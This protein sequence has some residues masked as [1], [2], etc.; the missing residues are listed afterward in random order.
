[1]L[2]VLGAEMQEYKVAYIRQQNVNLIIIPLDS[3][4]HYKTPA[5]QGQTIQALQAAAT[6][7]GLR[8]T[9]VPVWERPDGRMGFIAHINWHPFF[10][11]IDMELVTQNINQK[12]ACSR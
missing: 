11:S 9:V 7:A 5:Q 8:G 1:V 2:T 6:S 4:F 12:L 10:K 3:A